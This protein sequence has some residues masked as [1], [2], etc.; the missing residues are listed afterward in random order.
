MTWDAMALMWYFC[1]VLLQEKMSAF[2]GLVHLASQIWV[3]IE[4]N[5]SVNG[6]MPVRHQAII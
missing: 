4:S 3:N 1:N 2:C 6:L 5:E